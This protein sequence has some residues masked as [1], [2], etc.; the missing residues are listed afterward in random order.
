[1]NAFRVSISVIAIAL[2][3]LSAK[4]AHATQV[5]ACGNFDFDLSAGLSCKIEVEGGCSAEC[6]PLNF[7]AA[8]TGGCTATPDPN[9]VDGCGT[10]CVA[11]CNPELLDCFAGCHGECDV[12]TQELCEANGTRDDCAEV[13]VADCDIHCTESCEVPPS[14]CEE[15]CNRCCSGSCATAINFDCNLSC[16]AELTGG[17][18]VQCTKPDGAIFCN[19]QYVNAAELQTCIVALAAEGIEVD[20]SARGSVTCDLSG[21]DGEGSSTGCSTTAAGGGSVA[22]ALLGLMFFYWRRRR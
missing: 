9:C 17:C 10:Q 8:C 2:L 14:D 5:E 11:T 15:H 7:E 13:A 18:D 19:G 22:F 3:A 4:P 21:C 12:P 6:T 20:V 16:F 1:M